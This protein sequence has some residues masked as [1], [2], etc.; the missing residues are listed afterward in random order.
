MAAGADFDEG[1]DAFVGEVL[2]QRDELHRF[3]ELLGE[4]FTR[5]LLPRGI[6]LARRV[7]KH[8]LIAG[9]E[10]DVRDGLRERF[11]R[12]CDEGAVEGRG[13]DQAHGREVVGAQ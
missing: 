11:G 9:A 12:L 10:L 1:R 3:R 8:R 13:D 6:S 7:G 4:E 5:G 2:D